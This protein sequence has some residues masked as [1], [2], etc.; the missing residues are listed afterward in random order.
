MHNTPGRWW[1]LATLA[2]LGM[3][4][5]H[6]G[7]PGADDAGS[8]PAAASGTTPNIVADDREG[9]H[10]YGFG[11]N[12]E[13]PLADEGATGV[14]VRWGWNDGHTE[15][16]AFTEVE[17]VE[18]LGGQL[19]GSH[20]HRPDDRLGLALV[21]EAL[22]G[23]HRAYLAAGGVGFV[24]GDGRLTYGPEQTLEAYYRLQYVWPQQAGPVRWQAGPD[25]QY[26]RNPG[27]NRDRGPARFWALRLHL[28][29]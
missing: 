25:F 27:Y 18:T 15:S 26:I 8:G 19:A 22:S 6:A 13:Q 3:R 2:L 7:S 4:Y 21:S 10:K 9:R 5:A 1:R 12:A 11:V 24:L 28:E 16:F 23:T 17:Q 20:W 14:F 29:Y